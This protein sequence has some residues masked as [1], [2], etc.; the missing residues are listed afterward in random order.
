MKI[1][2][3]IGFAFVAIAAIAAGFVRAQSPRPGAAQ[4]NPE[5]DR[6]YE[7]DQKD[8]ENFNKLTTAQ[9]KQMSVND[10][11]RRVRAR[12]LLATGALHTG[13]DFTHAA[14]IFQHGDT[15]DDYLFAH[16]LA[17]AGMARGDSAAKW[18]AAATLDRYLQSAKQAQ[19]FGTQYR[20]EGG[21]QSATQSPYNSEL[22]SDALRKEFCV[23]PYADQQ[24]NVAAMRQGRGPVAHDGC[25]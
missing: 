21:P 3:G 2:M 4:N 17:M 20:W 12:E 10:S 11:Q 8:R 18:I 13:V 5:M 22:L 14:F 9:L 25:S 24:K 6:L 16:I 7:Q 1:G 19:V 15:A 23:S